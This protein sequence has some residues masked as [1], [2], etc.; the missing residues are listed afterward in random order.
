MALKMDACGAGGGLGSR[1][2]ATGSSSP[3]LL[4]VVR[5]AGGG[6]G[7]DGGHDEELTVVRGGEGWLLELARSERDDGA[8]CRERR[9]TMLLKVL[10]REN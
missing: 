3:L 1:R 2:S 9:M 7:P 4:C 8:V 5:G 10:E 6:A